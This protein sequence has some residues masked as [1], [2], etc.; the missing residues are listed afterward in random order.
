M[1]GI[2]DIER[3]LRRAEEH[4]NSVKAMESA[5]SYAKGHLV[6]EQDRDP[7][8]IAFRLRLPKIPEDFVMVVGDCVHNLRCVLDHIMWNIAYGSAA[9]VALRNQKKI[10]FPITGTPE[11]FTRQIARG[12][13]TGTAAEVR[14]L[15][16]SVQPYNAGYERLAILNELE[17]IDKHR[18]LVVVESVTDTVFAPETNPRTV[19][20]FSF[21]QVLLDNEVCL[22]ADRRVLTPSLADFGTV[23]IEISG[24]AR[25]MFTDEPMLGMLVGGTLSALVKIVGD[26]VLPMFKRF[27]R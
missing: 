5:V 9:D 11:E 24:H 18:A 12:R 2:T 6:P 3:K 14:A 25:I 13:L 20:F 15:V 4:L 26:D 22:R 1:P 7:Q 17:N 8:F 27:L 23:D 10:M 16:E 21:G 19:A